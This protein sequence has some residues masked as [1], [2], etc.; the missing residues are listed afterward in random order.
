MVA[1]LRSFRAVQAVARPALALPKVQVARAFSASALRAGGG[2]PP[3][4][5]GDG[6]SPHPDLALIT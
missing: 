3:Q 2:G 1:L 4:L 5:L 6:M